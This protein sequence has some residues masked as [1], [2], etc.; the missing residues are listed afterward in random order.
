[1]NKIKSKYIDM[2]LLYE[3]ILVNE[4]GKDNT[5]NLSLIF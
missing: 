1:M 4:V 3:L 5:Y 2:C